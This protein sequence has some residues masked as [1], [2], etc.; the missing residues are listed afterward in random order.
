MRPNK[1][2]RCVLLAMLVFVCSSLAVLQGAEPVSLDNL[3]APEPNKAD[4]PLAEMFSMER[5]VHF[6]DSAS[7]DWQQSWQC[8]TCHTNISYLMARP[9]VALDSPAHREVRKYAEE[10]ISLR[11]EEVG[12]RFDAEVVGIAAALA[13]NDA[14]TSKKLHPL[15]RVA[16]DRMWTTQRPEGD[17]KWP[18]NCRWPPMESDEH[19]GVTLAAIAAG[20]APDGYAQSPAAQAGL[21]K[22]RT[23]LKNHPPVDL[24]HKGMVLW[25]STYVDG[26]VSADERKK[27]IDELIAAERPGGGWGFATLYP[28]DRGDDKEQDLTATDGYGTGFVVFVLRRAGIAADHPAVVRGV[29]W[30]KTHQRKSGRWF[31]RSLNKD[32][33]HFISHAGSAFAVM[34]LAACGEK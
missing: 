5:A 15:T 7:L 14:A 20:A 1:L 4:E 27:W 18:I 33:E 16:L 22:V 9:T 21:A 3:V 10:L 32:N 2:V 6:L 31:T 25:A 29:T 26:L 28:W 17:W 34:A 23:F 13:L 24:H 30:L 8:F 19:Y 12:P 11:W